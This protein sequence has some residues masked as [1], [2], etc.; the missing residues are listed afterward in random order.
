MKEFRVR[1][2]DGNEKWF[3]AKDMMCVLNYLVEEL[4]YDANDIISIERR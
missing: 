1:F 3:D 4:N 2:A